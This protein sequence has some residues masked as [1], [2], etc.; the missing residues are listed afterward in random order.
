MTRLLQHS[1]S[2]LTYNFINYMVSSQKPS[3]ILRS[4]T[5][6]WIKET[7]IKNTTT[8]YIIGPTAKK[9]KTQLKVQKYCRISLILTTA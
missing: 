7:S 3:T 1:N 6:A 8:A 9:K 5:F 2:E 4:A